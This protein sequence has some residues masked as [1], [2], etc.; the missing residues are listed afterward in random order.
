MEVMATAL[1]GALSGRG[2][3]VHLI[4]TD[5]LGDLAEEA[6]RQHCTVQLAA[7]YRRGSA[8]WPRALRDAIRQR[9]PDIVHV[10]NAP[11]LKACWAARL[12]GAPAVVHT[13]H[14]LP[15]SVTAR[16]KHLMR[17][18]ARLTDAIAAVSEP[19][20]DYAETEL[21]VPRA[22]L[23]VIRNGIDVARYRAARTGSLRRALG[24][25][26]EALLVGIVAR[27]DPVKDHETMLTAFREVSA[28]VPSSHL[29]LIGDGELR[30]AIASRAREL[31]LDRRVHFLGT[32]RDIPAVLPE[33]DVV[34]LSS[35]AEGLP[36]AL[37][38]AMAA[39]RAVVATS[40]G[41]IPE[42]LRDGAGVTA[43]PGDPAAL[44]AA[45]VGLL[46][47]APAR[48]RA[49]EIARER[50]TTGYSLAVMAN[51]Y[52]AMYREVIARKRET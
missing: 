28:A 14:G 17:M 41:A 49:G 44:A 39:G 32:Q 36:M 13:F 38:E 33:L 47:D 9:A 43:P 11:W 25:D 34:A 6:V 24:L 3:G 40:V 1:A 37:L 10:H 8:L 20:T 15:A 23:R 18:G 22:K 19:L 21:H 7:S 30:A 42:L 4:C 2:H 50:V 16:D 52:E 45:L 27:F 12:A 51:A 48:A 31:E 26:D 29:V 35:R 5:A 46:R